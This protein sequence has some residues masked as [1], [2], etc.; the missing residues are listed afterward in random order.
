MDKIY[1]GAAY[2]PEL[3]DEEELEKDI[4]RC[5]EVGMNCLRIGEFAWG[6]MEP[7]EGKFDLSWLVRVVDRLYK[8]GIFTVLCTPTATPPRWML[9]KYP[10][11]RMI[12]HDL[13]R[14]DV[15]SRCHVCKTSPVAREKNRLIVTELAK[16]FAGHKGV[17]G[18]QIDNEPGHYGV[19]D[20]SEN[21]QA[22]FRIWLQ[23]KYGTIDKLNDTWGASFWSETY[24]NFEQVRLPNQQEVPD[25]ANPHA[26]LDLNRFMADELAGFV[27]MQADILR[28]HIHKDQWIT[29]NL[30]PIFNPVDP[31]RIDHPDFLT[32]T[33]YLVTGHNQGIGSQGFRM[34]IPEDLGF[35]NDQFRNRVGKAFGV[36][37]LQPGQV[38]W[39][40]YN[41]QPLPGAIRMWVY[42]VFAGGGKF[43]CNYR[44][45]QPLKGSEQYHYGMIMTDGVTLSPGGEEYVRIT[46]EMKKLRAAYDKKNRMPGQLASR[47]IG[48]LF[49][50]SNY[51]EMEFQ[52]Q[53]DQWRTMAHVHKYYNLLKSFAAP[54]DVISEKEDFSGYPFLIA[55]AYQ[56]LDNKLVERWTEYV[57]KGGHLI[58]TCRTGQKDRDAKLWEAPLAAPI[59]QLAGINS[60]YYDHLPHNLYGKIDFEGKEFA[61]NNWGDVLT[62]AA[63]TDVWAVYTDQ[64]YKGAASV[65]HRKLGK[66]TVTYIGTD[67]DDGKLEKEVVRRVYTEAGV[68]TEDL[69]YGVVKEWRDGFYIALNYTSDV[70]EIAILDKAE[71]L[72]GSARLE[73]AGVVV[74]KEKSDN[75]HK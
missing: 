64:F 46:Q 13:V 4:A 58:L 67:T 70:Q 22:K 6:K 11:M 48:L 33:R 2:Y 45:R 40:V 43:V 30:I 21:A 20:Y 62:P 42:H 34:G 49:D 5:K 10:E 23:K 66:G 39:G 63:G 44:F 8:N 12:M 28:R 14:A 73:A 19:V 54:V 65:I 53:T 51:W 3:W 32:Y 41:P 7:E 52:R 17:F 38:N 25:K 69:P 31:V 71:I 74:W 55:P 16:M 57:K 61:W 56:L 24:Q 15:S 50:M 47:R 29:T 1:L 59:H 26:M 36:M 9:N 35:S 68:S 37:E 27:N 75:R 72:I 18:W 60:L